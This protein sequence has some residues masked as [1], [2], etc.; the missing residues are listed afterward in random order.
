VGL[1]HNIVACHKEDK[2]E[3][4][5]PHSGSTWQSFYPV[6]YFAPQEWQRSKDSNILAR[7]RDNEGFDD[8]G[9][10]GHCIGENTSIN[11]ILINGN[12]DAMD[13][14]VFFSGVSR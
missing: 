14:D 2:S 11:T 7:I 10:V 12:S 9:A 5:S 3:E 6:F 4:L 13:L 8:L 1:A